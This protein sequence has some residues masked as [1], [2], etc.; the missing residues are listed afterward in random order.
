MMHYL[1]D[2]YGVIYGNCQNHKPIRAN[3]KYEAN[4]ECHRND[5]SG[6]IDAK[7]KHLHFR[8]ETREL[9]LHSLKTN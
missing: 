9:P 8:L 7:E 2:E 3:S 1:Y 6:K 5:D 4:V